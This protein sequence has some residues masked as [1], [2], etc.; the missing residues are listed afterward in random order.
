MVWFVHSPTAYVAMDTTDIKRSG[1]TIPDMEQKHT[2]DLHIYTH[3]VACGQ[4]SCDTSCDMY[5]YCS[6]HHMTISSPDRDMQTYEQIHTP[7]LNTNAYSQVHMPYQ[8][9]PHTKTHTHTLHPSLY[10]CQGFTAKFA[11][12]S[13]FWNIYKYRGWAKIKVFLHQIA[14]HA[15]FKGIYINQG[16]GLSN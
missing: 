9:P 1:K 7:T 4:K 14:C 11:T 6:R 12:G 5:A 13:G 16:V 3:L 15:V 10:T 2:P 8:I